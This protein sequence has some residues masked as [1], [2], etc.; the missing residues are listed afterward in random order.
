MLKKEL[1]AWKFHLANEVLL[2]QSSNKNVL[3]LPLVT[4]RS[5]G[6]FEHNFHFKLTNGNLNTQLGVEVFSNTLYRAYSFMPSTGFYY[7]TAAVKT[8]N[9]P[10]LTAFLNVKIKRTRILLMLDHFNQGMT[11]Y[12]YSLVP[13]NPMGIM[14]FRYGLAWTFYD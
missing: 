9:Y 5:A 12:N 14:Y 10:Y 6:F 2:Q 7:N 8:G 3:D 13:S 11:G 4:V 1:R